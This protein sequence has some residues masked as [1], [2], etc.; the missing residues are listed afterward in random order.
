LP[1]AVA[2][3]RLSTSGP[4]RAWAEPPSTVAPPSGFAITGHGV[5]ESCAGTY[6][7]TRPRQ[8][9]ALPVP[10][11]GA[12]MWRPGA[13]PGGPGRPS[14]RPQRLEPAT[15]ARGAHR[16]SAAARSV[17]AAELGLP[18]RK[19]ALRPGRPPPRVGRAGPRPDPRRRLRDRG[20]DQDRGWGRGFARGSPP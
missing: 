9:G 6:S 14:G 2:P 10:G 1:Q 20:V 3:A 5:G 15:A 12:P 17:D 18:D 7:R 11:A 8:T 19:P 4:A 13:V 16:G